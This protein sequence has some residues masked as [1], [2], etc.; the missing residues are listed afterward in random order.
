MSKSEG[1]IEDISG[2][3]GDQLARLAAQLEND[4]VEL[5]S[6][7]NGLDPAGLAE[8]R[9]LAETALAAARQLSEALNN[10]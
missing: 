4:Q 6:W 5:V 3:A 7:R 10:C 1:S 9:R 8:G 2:K